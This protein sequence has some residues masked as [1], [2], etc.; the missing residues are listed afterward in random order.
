[1]QA[2][3]DKIALT[4]FIDR[5]NA[6]T[7]SVLLMD[8]DGT[9]APFQTE[10]D[11]AYP[12]P[13][14]V[15]ILESIIR[16]GKTRVILITGRPIGELQALFSPI[17]SLEVWGAHG[18]EHRLAD[19]TY[20]QTVINPEIAA[21]LEQAR[22]W[23]IATELVSLTEI[24]PGGIAIH[25][26]GLTDAE[27]MR[28]QTRALEGWAPLAEQ[29]GL[30]LLNFEAGLELRIAHPD[31]GDVVAAIL[32]DLNPHVQIAFLGDDL[33]DEDAFR[34]LENRGLSVLVRPRYR[35]TRA[36]V[37][38]KPPHEL[39]GFFEQWLNGISA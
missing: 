5:L 28:V 21:V 11:R 35:E 10:R 4:D 31:K 30:K 16:S 20:L 2:P 34:A 3:H 19:G 29:P 18:L 12:Y 33:T 6:A 26:R 8:Y 13:G 14:V 25:W 7:E 15:P 37:W 32:E 1:M 27:I 36:K 17:N 39:I 23:L 38:L 24:K 9:L 22:K